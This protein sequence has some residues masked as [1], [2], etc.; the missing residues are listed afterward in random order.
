MSNLIFVRNIFKSW[1]VFFMM[2]SHGNCICMIQETWWIYLVREND[3]CWDKT[4]GRMLLCW[5]K[6]PYHMSQSPYSMFIIASQ[7]GTFVVRISKFALFLSDGGFENDGF[8]KGLLSRE[9]NSQF[10]RVIH[11][12]EED[13]WMTSLWWEI[14]VTW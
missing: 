4:C 5:E 10:W 13:T 12:K 1:I 7:W 9:G 11:R 14:H 6:N 8:P 2:V 3:G